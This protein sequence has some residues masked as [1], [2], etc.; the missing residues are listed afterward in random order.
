MPHPYR[1]ARRRL[2]RNAATLS[3]ANAKFAAGLVCQVSAK[4]SS[5]TSLT[6][7]RTRGSA[8]NLA[9][10]LC[11]VIEASVLSVGI[12]KMPAS[13]IRET[14]SGVCG[15]STNRCVS[16]STPAS[17]ARC[18]ASNVSVCARTLSPLACAS[19]TA[20]SSTSCART[21]TEVP[22][23]WPSSIMTLR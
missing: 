22:K 9:P 10:V 4:L 7:G 20:A 8:A 17:T 6:L 16:P 14:I 5:H 2:P 3:R 19:R 11:P 18:V 15:A 21:G 1:P 13:A 23:T 12:T